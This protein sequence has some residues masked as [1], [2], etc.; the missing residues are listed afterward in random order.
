MLSRE[1]YVQ[2]GL[3]KPVYLL[4]LC[5][6]HMH[7]YQVRVHLF[8][9]HKHSQTAGW[10]LLK[11]A[12]I[13]S[14]FYVRLGA[15]INNFIN[16]TLKEYTRLQTT[17]YPLKE[18]AGCFWGKSSPKD[19]I[20]SSHYMPHN[21]TTR[22]RKFWPWQWFNLQFWSEKLCWKYLLINKRNGSSQ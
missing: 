19:T 13:Q 3:A 6:Y 16:Q 12:L 5:L 17:L 4:W 9:C 20:C 21:E 7:T 11:V 22:N 14:Q 18:F 1:T 2:A 10:K 15:E 8:I